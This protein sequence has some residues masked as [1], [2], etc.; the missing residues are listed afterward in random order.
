MSFVHLHVHSEYSLLDGACRVTE[1]VDRAKEM[2]QTAVAITD[3]GVMFAIADFYKYALSKGIKPIIGCE[4]YTAIGSMYEK[5]V[6]DE[7]RYGHL[8]LLAETDEGYH[9]LMKIV[10]EGFVHGFYYKPRVDKA[11]L[12]K[13]AKGIIALSACLAGDIPR[14]LLADDYEGAKKEALEF[15]DIFG[16][17]NFF[18][19]LQ[20]HGIKEQ[21][22]VNAYLIRLGKE[23]NLPFVVT[24]DAHY[25]KKEDAKVQDLLMCIQM[26]KTVADTDRMKF[27]TDE[28]YLKSEEEMRALFPS[29]PEAADNT[30][31]IAERCNA[32]IDFS[33][34]HLPD[35]PLPEGTSHAEYLRNL[36]M[37]G[38]KERYADYKENLPRLE[39]ELSVIENM[40]FVDYFLIVWDVIRFARSQN[41]PVGPGRGSAAGSLVSYCL[42][43][44]DIDPIRY[45]LLFERFLNPERVSMPDIDMDFCYI[46]RP[47]VIEYVTNKYGSDHVA[48]IITFGTLAARAAVRDVGRTLGMPYSAVD[49]VAKLIPHDLNITLD[50]AIAAN[51]QLKALMRENRQ[52]LE[53][54]ELSKKIEGMPRNASTHA[55]GVLITGKPTMEY[56]PL[57]LNDTSVTSQYTMT[58]LEELGLLKIDFLGL[59]TLTV[60]DNAVRLV[61]KRGI[62]LDIEHIP[63]DD[64]KVYAMLSAG[65]TDGVFQMESSGMRRFLRDLKPASLE[66]II[67]GISLYRPG[68][69]D[70]I[71]TYIKNKN[72]PNEVTYLHPKLK[73]ILE[74]T[75]GC[76]VY[77]EQVMQIV[78]SLAGFS[79]GGADGVRRAMSKK[80]TDVMNAARQDFIYGSEEKGIDGA[81]KRGIPEPIA[82][83]IFGQMSDFA[84]YAFN[85]SHAAAYAVVAYRTAYL[86]CHYPV[87]FFASLMSSFKD[88]ITKIAEYMQVCRKSG[89]QVRV[90]DVNKSYSDFSVEEN[91]IRFGLSAIK[92]VGVGVIS[93]LVAEREQNGEFKTFHDFCVRMCKFQSINKRAVEGMIK[94]GAFDGL[95]LNRA[96]LLL[97]YED[98]LDRASSEQKTIAA[99]QISFFDTETEEPALQNHIPNVEELD[100]T[101][102]LAQENEFM[103]VY[104]SGHPVD[105]FEEQLMGKTNADTLKIRESFEEQMDGRGGALSDGVYVTVAGLIENVQVKITR[106]NEKMAILTLSDRYGM[107]EVLLFSRL[108]Q[109]FANVLSKGSVAVFSGRLSFREDKDVSLV[110]ENVYSVLNAPN[111]ARLYLK[112]TDKNRENTKEILSLLEKNHGDTPVIFYDEQKKQ[113]RQAPANYWVRLSNALLSNLK[114]YLD[115]SEIK[116]VERAESTQRNRKG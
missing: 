89:I 35:F 111:L 16:K 40:G 67:A 20:N 30:V 107:I 71:P 26:R 95:D 90:P 41:I 9:N 1:L 37:T 49:T 31:K 55:A 84:K 103:G 78:R 43:I 18:L 108:Y 112:I 53:L 75:Y 57:Y 61:R 32:K 52:V 45:Q 59:R 72:H 110:C 39:Y 106:R 48:Q 13:Y 60:I 73:E 68:P 104:I 64:E 25:L 92:N 56:V 19:E 24:N 7:N 10:S 42:K 36:C 51:D 98:E 14:H 28:F 4:V 83:E 65:E 3:H 85:K 54:M 109:S 91:C 21:E 116:I 5:T 58:R 105:K 46:R 96:Q 79:M 47:E 114:D 29:L 44:T 101:V 102:R 94:S 86:K 100:L 23:L 74:V 62:T 15:V 63:L 22:K 12:K 99:G 2:G 115:E 33:T 81:I 70:S 88:R 76:I 97:M 87:E 11:C 17:N 38:L 113:S 6:T 82:A 80:K 69:M 8:V 27:E 50:G 66:E 77:Q 34:R 93:D